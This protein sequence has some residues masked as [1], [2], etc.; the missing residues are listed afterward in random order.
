[1]I[2]GREGRL[3]ERANLMEGGIWNSFLSFS[4]AGHSKVWEIFR[5]ESRSQKSRDRGNRFD[6]TWE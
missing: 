1:M 2:L 4:R 3:L 6:R 5:G